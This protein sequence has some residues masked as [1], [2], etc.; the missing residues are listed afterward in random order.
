MQDLDAVKHPDYQDLD[1]EQ[2]IEGPPIIKNQAKLLIVFEYHMREEPSIL[3][4]G[5]L[6]GRQSF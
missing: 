4:L 5:Q 6:H 2:Q 1:D 3:I